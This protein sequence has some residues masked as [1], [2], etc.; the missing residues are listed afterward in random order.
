MTTTKPGDSG[1][2]ISLSGYTI[3]IHKAEEGETGYWG[4]V[5]GMP[6]CVS[7]GETISELK[8][9]MLE[10]MEAV[11]QHSVSSALDAPSSSHLRT[12]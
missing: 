8:A 10:A 11:R 7:Q 5:V 9:N 3:L 1:T 4:E 6:G 12:S 2:K